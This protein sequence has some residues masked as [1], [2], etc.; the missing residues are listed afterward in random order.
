VEETH[1][2]EDFSASVTG[3]SPRPRATAKQGQYLS[4]IYYYTKIHSEPPAEADL[5]RY[6]G[7]SAPAVHQMIVNL[8]ERGL[9]ARTAGKA[10]TIRLLVTREEIPD[11]E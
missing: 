2:D 4:F 7:V 11:L 10:R 6:F 9:I 3:R 1:T 5:Q 8:E